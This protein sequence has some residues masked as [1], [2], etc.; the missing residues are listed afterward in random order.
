VPLAR[1]GAFELDFRSQ[2]LRKGGVRLA[3]PGQ[4]VQLLALLLERP[5]ELVTREAL[6]RGLWPAGTF[7]DFEHGLNTLV[8]RLRRVL[9]DSADAPRFIETLP[10]RGY[11]FIAPVQVGARAIHGPRS[12]L[13]TVGAVLMLIVTGGWVLFRGRR[14]GSRA[15]SDPADFGQ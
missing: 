7:V 12:R 5:G 3:M 14:V 6:R 2:E 15:L 13:A 11:R 9:G 1:F 4:C 8:K 10:R